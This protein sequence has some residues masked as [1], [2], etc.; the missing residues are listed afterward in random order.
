MRARAAARPPIKPVLWRPALRVRPIA[1]RT[2][3][4]SDSTIASTIPSST[5][6]NTTD[7]GRMRASRNSPGLSRRNRAKPRRSMRP[8]AIAKT[9]GPARNAAEIAAARQE[10]QYKSDHHC[11]RQLSHLAAA[12]GAFDHRGLRGTAVNHERSA[13]GS[14]RV[15]RRQAHQVVVLYQDLVMAGRRRSAPWPRSGPRSSRST[16]QR[17]RSARPNSCQVACGI[18]ICGRPPATRPDDS[19][20]VSRELPITLATSAPNTA[21]QRA[22]ESLIHAA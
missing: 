10:Q 3:R 1:W 20:S 5:S 2:W 22:R 21:K 6:I 15:R 9:I 7:R 8:T 13:E 4:S 18:V 14:G 16:R 11:G 12:T 17:F 19:D